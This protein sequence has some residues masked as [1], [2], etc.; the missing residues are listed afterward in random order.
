MFRSYKKDIE[1]IYQRIDK[2]AKVGRDNNQEYYN[3]VDD[4]ISKSQYGLLTQ[5]LLIKYNFDYTRYLSVD[6][7]K[8][9]SWNA[10]LFLTNSKIQD[11]LEDFKVKLGI[12]QIGLDYFRNVIIGDEIQVIKLGSINEVDTYVNSIS[13]LAYTNNEFQQLSKNKQLELVVSKV[14]ELDS[15]VFSDWNSERSYDKNVT[16]LYRSAIE[17][18]VSI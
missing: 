4:L 3:L 11:D 2:V 18:L 9:D 14:G 12:Y 1:K 16:L 17:Y 13:P 7:I 10:V 15:V 6:D 8:N 5:V